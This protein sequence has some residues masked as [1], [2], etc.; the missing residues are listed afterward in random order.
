MTIDK[1][2]GWGR[3][4]SAAAPSPTIAQTL[5]MARIEQDDNFEALTR[6]VNDAG[7]NIRLALANL[8]PNVSVA[9]PGPVSTLLDDL[10]TLLDTTNRNIDCVAQAITG[11]P[12]LS[13]IAT[14]TAELRQ[15]VC[16]AGERVRL[17]AGMMNR[18]A[19]WPRHLSSV[20]IRVMLHLSNLQHA[21]LKAMDEKP[22]KQ[23]A[24]TLIEYEKSF[25]SDVGGRNDIPAGIVDEIRKLYR[26]ISPKEPQK[27]INERLIELARV[28]QTV[29][30][31]LA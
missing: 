14:Q 3:L 6:A 31:E 16:E 13:T 8:N 30:V 19:E 7:D 2:G 20:A 26:P 28:E 17:L 29:I 23:L 27:E 21:L 15:C 24:N 5:C 10:K 11:Q 25:A 12:S 4:P 9:L 18:Q 1:Y 22:P